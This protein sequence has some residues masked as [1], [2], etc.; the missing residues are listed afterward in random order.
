ML[1][2][3]THSNFRSLKI[4]FSSASETPKDLN[5]PATGPASMR[6]NVYW[7]TRYH[8]LAQNKN[9]K[10]GF[11]P[12]SGVNV[13]KVAVKHKPKEEYV[14]ETWFINNALYFRSSHYYP[15]ELGRGLEFCEV[16]FYCWEWIC[17][18][19]DSSAVLKYLQWT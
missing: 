1:I 13:H 2:S 4:T 14:Y 7:L 15:T 12:D 17:L 19:F 9:C 10:M 11:H 6:S 8:M 16:S 3:Y 5:W 18:V